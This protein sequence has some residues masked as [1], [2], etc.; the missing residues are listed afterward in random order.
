[1]VARVANKTWA[2]RQSA[3]KNSPLKHKCSEIW[4]FWR[5]GRTFSRFRAET[6]PQGELFRARHGNYSKSKRSRP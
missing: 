5:A 3:R 2:Q 1:V 6:E 4:G